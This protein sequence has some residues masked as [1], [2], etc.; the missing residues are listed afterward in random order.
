[1]FDQK[2]GEFD[3]FVA[4]FTP[5]DKANGFV[6]FIHDR[7]LNLEIFN[8]RDIHAE[9]FP[10][11]LKGVAVEA[12]GLKPRKIPLDENSAGQKIAGLLSLLEEIPTEIHPGVA[13]GTERRFGNEEI[14][15]FDLLYND[16]RIHLTA[17][18]LK[19]GDRG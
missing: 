12:F 1:M 18:N 14:T 17:M 10:R 15:G 2:R 11:I 19:Q 3:A 4:G 7:I 6:T 9:Y 16:H 5:S 8:R 13:L